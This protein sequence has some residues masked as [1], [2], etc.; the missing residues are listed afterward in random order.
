MRFLECLKSAGKVL[1]RNNYLWSVMKKSIRLSHAKVHVFS[2]S[3]HQV[4]FGNSSWV[5]S[6]IHHNTEL[7]TQLTENGW[8]SSRIFSQ[9]SP[10]CSSPTK[11]MSS[12]LKWAT[13]HN[14]KDELSSCRCSMT[15]YV[16]LK[17][18]NG[19]VLLT[20]LL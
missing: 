15:S 2:D 10:H 14:S 17:T 18:M 8:N 19:N 7:W 16:D 6:R 9:D 12:C 4:L 13:H 3:Q 11:S 5:G 20:P 1:H